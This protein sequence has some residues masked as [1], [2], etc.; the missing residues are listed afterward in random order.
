MKNIKKNL[1]KL[2]M[3]KIKHPKIKHLDKKKKKI[4][5]QS[6]KYVLLTIGSL[7]VFGKGYKYFNRNPNRTIPS[8]NNF[9]AP[10]DGIVESIERDNRGYIK[11]QIFIGLTDVHYQRS[12]FFGSVVNITGNSSCNKIELSTIFGN[13]TIERWSG[14]LARTVVTKV[15]VG[16][17]VGKG[18]I[19]GRI[20]LGSHCSITIP[21]SMTISVCVGDHLLAGETVVAEL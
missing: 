16:D 8:G 7:L 2:K 4:D 21:K 1:S 20:L 12:P 17:I 15:K 14:I 9:V 5:S 13:T 3:P 10:A 18:D 11:I 6:T 19:I